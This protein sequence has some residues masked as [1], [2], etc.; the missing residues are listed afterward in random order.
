MKIYFDQRKIK[1]FSGEDVTI[2]AVLENHS[3]EESVIWHK[4]TT[5][6]SHV[7]DTSLP[8][9]FG[10]KKNTDNHMLVIRD[11][12]ELDTGKYYLSTNHRN[13]RD[14]FTSN[15]MQLDIIRGKTVY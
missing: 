7:V 9:Y 12:S 11:C 15:K 6:G 1:F 8:K 14:V 5:N 13:K 2:N 4:E 3:T 10:I